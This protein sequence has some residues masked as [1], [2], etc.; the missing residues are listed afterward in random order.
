MRVVLAALALLIGLG[1][2]AAWACSCACPKSAQEF[3]AGVP[4]FFRGAPLSETVSEQE[5]RYVFATSAVHKGEVGQ[6]VTVGTALHEA[7]CGV[8]FAIGKEVLVGAY[9]REGVLRVNQCTQYCIG[10]HAG[11]IDRMLTR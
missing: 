9:P 1:T 3:V 6:R 8:R 2:E 10:R 4:V 7:A 5:R 11:E